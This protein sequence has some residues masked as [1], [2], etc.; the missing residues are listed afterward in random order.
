MIRVIGGNDCA[1][2][3]EETDSIK[4]VKSK[5]QDQETIPIDQQRLLYRGHDLKDGLTISFYK[6]LD[7]TL[8]NLVIYQKNKIPI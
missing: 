6:I 5:I 7:G 1:V 2:V 4:E 8:L 3:V